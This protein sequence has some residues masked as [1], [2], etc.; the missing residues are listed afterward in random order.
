M[1]V[2]VTA[3]R[4][5][6]REILSGDQCVLPASVHDPLAGRIAQDL[7]FEVAMFAGSIASLA[8]LGAPDLVLL[9]LTEFAE[10]ARR[11]T[12]AIDLPLIADADHG[13]GNAL[14]VMRTV[15]ELETAGVAAITIED[16]ELPTAFGSR[17]PRLV[18]IDEAVGKVR[19]A[20]AARNDS[21]L[22]IVG[23]T[24]APA[25]TGIDDA[26]ERCRAFQAAGADAVF[27]SGIGHRSD[28]EK[29]CEAVRVPVLLGALPTELQDVQYLSEIGV[30]VA[31]QGHLPL[32]AALC[33]IHETMKALRDGALPAQINGLLSPAA[34]DHL[35]RVDD[36]R[37][38][39]EKYL[40]G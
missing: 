19:A 35:A 3:R 30:R 36:Y 10:Q 17:G 34:T 21:Q 33:A 24:S 37:R 15:E 5:R 6:L 31:L 38:W 20:I 13:Y 29:L 22:V 7:G 40:N 25:I 18:S 32:R 27:L 23:R 39:T 11:I 8:V 9:T 14:N 26:I 1:P 4:E 2:K 28:L 12:R 16:T